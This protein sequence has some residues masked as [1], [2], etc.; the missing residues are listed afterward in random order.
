MYSDKEKIKNKKEMLQILKNS[1]RMGVGV[2]L[3]PNPP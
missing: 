1:L 2:I 3:Y